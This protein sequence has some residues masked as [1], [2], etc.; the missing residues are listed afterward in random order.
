MS[1]LY[2]GLYEPGWRP[3][4]YGGRWSDLTVRHLV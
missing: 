2:T 3:A 4:T 1:C